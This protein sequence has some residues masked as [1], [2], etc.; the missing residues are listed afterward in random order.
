MQ[1]RVV[2][3]F[4]EIMDTDLAAATIRTT[5]GDDRETAGGNLF[6]L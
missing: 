1:R 2:D 6:E 3:R 5:Q 4:Y